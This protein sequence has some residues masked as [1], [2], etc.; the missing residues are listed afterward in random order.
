MEPTFKVAEH[1][2]NENAESND[3]AELA[4]LELAV[5]GG[6]IGETIL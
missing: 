4:A 1:N 5:V 6:G 3:F 2:N